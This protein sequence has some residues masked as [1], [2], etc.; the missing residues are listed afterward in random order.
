[1][2]L[3]FTCDPLTDYFGL[4]W[5]VSHVSWEVNSPSP[6]LLWDKSSSGIHSADGHREYL[7]VSESNN[8]HSTGQACRDQGSLLRSVL[9]CG[10]V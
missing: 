2:P 3:G 1:M 10:D 6:L 7:F 8:V 9:P 5:G 4:Q